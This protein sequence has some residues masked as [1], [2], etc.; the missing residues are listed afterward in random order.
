MTFITLLVC[1]VWDRRSCNHKLL[2]FLPP[3]SSTVNNNMKQ[4]LTVLT[5]SSPVAQPHY[6]AFTPPC[7]CVIFSSHAQFSEI[8]D[9]ILDSFPLMNS[10][11]YFDAKITFSFFW[12]GRFFFCIISM[13]C[14]GT[15]VPWHILYGVGFIRLPS[16]GFWG[17]NSDGRHLYPVSHLTRLVL[18]SFSFESKSCYV[19]QDSLKLK[20]PWVLGFSTCSTIPD[21]TIPLGPHW[22]SKDCPGK[23]WEL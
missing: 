13:S 15:R 1:S 3:D 21:S 4:G 8:V 6:C 16:C 2:P 5:V 7:L 23:I 22:E 18:F 12:G 10:F 20:L 14:W 11:V 19:A 9:C 17:P